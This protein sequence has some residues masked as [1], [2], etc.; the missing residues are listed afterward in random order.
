MK[1]QVTNSKSNRRNFPYPLH[2]RKNA[3][4]DELC[5][6]EVYFQSHVLLFINKCGGWKK[7][8]AS[9]IELKNRTTVKKIGRMKQISNIDIPKASIPDSFG[10]TI[11]LC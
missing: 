6:L 9:P 7:L 8:L 10:M 1:H 3:L 5:C 11:I 4:P 2:I